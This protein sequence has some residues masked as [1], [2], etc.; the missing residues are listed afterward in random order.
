MKVKTTSNKDLLQM[1]AIT[2][3]SNLDFLKVTNNGK[4]SAWMSVQSINRCAF[5]CWSICK[6]KFCQAIMKETKVR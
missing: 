3:L 2:K 4:L 1:Y 6:V 5:F